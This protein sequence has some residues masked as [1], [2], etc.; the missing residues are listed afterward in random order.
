MI[1]QFFFKQFNLACHLFAHSLNVKQFYLSRRWN[2]SSATSSGQSGS[3]SNGKKRVLNIPAKL[4]DWSLT[5]RSLN[6]IPGPSLGESYPSAKMQS[7]YSTAPADCLYCKMLLEHSML[8][9]MMLWPRNHTWL[10]S[11]HLMVIQLRRDCLIFG[12]FVFFVLIFLWGQHIYNIKTR[13][14]RMLGLVWG[15][16]YFEP[17]KP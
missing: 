17:S 13:K 2:L 15:I 11:Y 6:A 10:V 16:I 9:V 7:V 14:N 1:K 4:Q 3:G 5:I 8:V 12:S